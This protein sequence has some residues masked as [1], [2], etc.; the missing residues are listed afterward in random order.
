[1]KGNAQVQ[2]AENNARFIIATVPGKVGGRCLGWITCLTTVTPHLP[3]KL[4]TTTSLFVILRTFL[5]VGES[6]DSETIVS[7]SR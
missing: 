6:A 7:S 4:R 1:M 3:L 5:K 2:A